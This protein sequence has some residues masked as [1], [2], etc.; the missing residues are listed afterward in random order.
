MDL[1]EYEWS[2]RSGPP[3]FDGPPSCSQHTFKNQQTSG[4]EDIHSKAIPQTFIKGNQIV[5]VGK[6]VKPRRSQGDAHCPIIS[7]WA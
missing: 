1:I 7:F 2:D 5:T 3:L 4:L 6:K